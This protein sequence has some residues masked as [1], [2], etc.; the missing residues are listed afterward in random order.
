M[1]RILHFFLPLLL[2]LL[3]VLPVEAQTL[4]QWYRSR[5]GGVVTY[6]RALRDLDQ[7]PAT[8]TGNNSFTTA[9]NNFSIQPVDKV[10]GVSWS[11]ARIT[12]LA[13]RNRLEVE[14]AGDAQLIRFE[15]LNGTPLVGSNPDGVSLNSNDFYPPAR[16]DGQG[17]YTQKWVF[18][19][20]KEGSGGIPAGPIKLT[21]RNAATGETFVHS[22][23][24]VSWASRAQIFVAGNSSPTTPATQV[25][26]S[27]YS[28]DGGNGSYNAY[29]AAPDNGSYEVLLTP[30]SAQSGY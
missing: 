1:K 28:Y 9:L 15:N 27:G 18:E 17:S 21:F 7:Y 16:L 25:L 13:S 3:S 24:P 4:Y 30:L 10:S 20:T 22:F 2:A 14:A 19:K 6:K 23:I 12:Y 29:L 26:A 11:S 5:K 8:T